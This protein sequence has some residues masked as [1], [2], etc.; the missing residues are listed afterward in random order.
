MAGVLIQPD[1]E[2]K[3]EI[4]G[5]DAHD[6]SSCYQCGTCSAVCPISTAD[7]PF[8]RKEMVWVQ[9]GLKER[10]LSNPS[11]WLCHQCGVCNAYCPRDAK[12]A[13]LMAALRDYSIGYYAV[14]IFMG[15]WLEAPRYLPMLFLIPAVIL[16][17]MVAWSGNLGSLPQGEVIFAKFIPDFTIEVVYSIAVGLAIIGGV[18]GGLRYWNAMT[19]SLAQPAKEPDPFS[20][21]VASIAEIFQHSQFAACTADPAG[22]KETH[23]EHLWGTHLLVFYGFLGLVV[24]TT[25]VWIGQLFFNY[26]EPFPLW[27]PVKILGNVSGIAVIGALTVFFLRRI[28]D[29]TKAGKS[30]YSDWLFLSILALTALTGYANEAL[31]LADVRLVAYPMYFIHLVLVFFLLVY[32]PYSK[33]GHVVYR[34]AA[35][36]FTAGLAAPSRDAA[37]A[38]G[39]TSSTGS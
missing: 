10:V 21:F 38:N 11:I 24:T 18:S 17:T 20:R 26:Y 29:G 1:L 31:R 9:W 32:F 23:K 22:S 35:M 33:F 19:R 16:L 37:T 2:F 39:M 6:L 25:S 36:L 7:N 12:P 30:T 5:L 4:M 34:T 3:R 27:H 28:V 8:P 14:P 15:R 13:N